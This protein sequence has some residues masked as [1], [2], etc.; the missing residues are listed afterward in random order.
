VTLVR[1]G[2]D[3]FNLIILSEMNI[4]ALSENTIHINGTQKNTSMKYEL[5]IKD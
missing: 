5:L 4:V 2:K 3:V 1:T